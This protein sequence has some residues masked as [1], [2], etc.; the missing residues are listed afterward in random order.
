[1]SESQ[2]AY[3]PG[4]DISFNSRLLRTAFK[5]AQDKNK[6][7]SIISLD[8]RKAFDSVSHSYLAQVMQAYGFPAEFIAIFT[9]LYSDNSALVQVNG[10]LSSSFK[11][12]RGVKQGDALS[13]GLFVLDMDPLIRNLVAND[14]IKG[15]N[16]P[17]DNNE[18]EEIKVLAYADDVAVICKNRSFQS[19][20]EEYERLT[21]VS[22]LEL[23]ADKTEIFNLIESNHIGSNIRYMGVDY[24]LGRTNL[25]K[26]CGLHLC[27][28]PDVEYQRNV[29][30]AI[31]KM[32]KIITAW[33]NRG[34]SL[35]GR[36]VAAKTFVLS[37]IVFQAQVVEIATKEVKRIERL[38]YSFVNGSRSLYGPERIARDKL[39]STKERGGINGVDIETFITAIKIRQYSKAMDNHRVLGGLQS[40]FKGCKDELSVS[41]SSALRAH[42]RTTL[43][44]IILEFD[45][46]TLVSGIPLQLFLTP[47]TRAF[48]YA[49]SLAVSTLYE[50]QRAIGNSRLTRTQANAIINQLPVGIRPLIRNNSFLDSPVSIIVSTKS[51]SFGAVKLIKSSQLRSRLLEIKKGFLSVQA[52][53]VYKQPQWQEPE[54]WQG[55][56]W[57]IKN[58][59]IRSYR[60]KILYKDIFSNERR[61]RFNLTDSP[62]C[63]L[64]G[65]IESVSHQ[66]LECPNAQRL[67]T[68]YHRLT[69]KVVNSMLEIISFTDSLENE[70]MKS[71]II[72]RL[73]QIDR[74]AGINFVA[75]K[76]EIKHYFRIEA[77][78]S[79]NSSRFWLQCAMN[80]EL[81]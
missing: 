36:M 56:I 22:G 72:K 35:N 47:N 3:V 11:I 71:I 17:I 25:I 58:P 65:Q 64:C 63:V 77:C 40:S 59:H 31:A 4:R 74:S 78:S 8:A 80:V 24:A 46:I 29:L 42:Y 27:R 79:K 10:H 70:I 15:L 57:K 53:D 18:V 48:S 45:L 33:K 28:Q 21:K 43:K 41:V 69:G 55:N 14:S 68:M 9:T 32:E 38:I 81:A 16:I 76:A 5:Y 26:I 6:D 39:K 44:E 67:W 19:V 62:N 52:K 20:F 23:N 34:L 60:L 50:L 66:L 30:D 2:A 37:Q 51:E 54:N 75:L 13:C 49:A 61:F 12:E 7:Y 1:M 73:I